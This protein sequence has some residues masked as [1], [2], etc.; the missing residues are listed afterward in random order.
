M[1]EQSSDDLNQTRNQIQ[2]I[3]NKNRISNQKIS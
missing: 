2:D 1:I 3:E